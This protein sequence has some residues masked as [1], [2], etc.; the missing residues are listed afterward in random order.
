MSAAVDGPDLNGH[1]RAADI[2]GDQGTPDD[3]T[4]VSEDDEDLFG[5]EDDAAGGDDDENK[6]GPPFSRPVYRHH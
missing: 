4:A 2:M 1:R 3:F 6:Y 5:D